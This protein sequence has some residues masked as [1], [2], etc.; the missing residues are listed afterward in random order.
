MKLNLKLMQSNLI[1]LLAQLNLEYK[2]LISRY[3]NITEVA[4]TTEREKEWWRSFGEHSLS[5]QTRDS[6]TVRPGGGKN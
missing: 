4:Y 2:K 1:I 6:S 3:Q 5:Q